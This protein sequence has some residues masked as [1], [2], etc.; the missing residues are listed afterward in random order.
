MN[1]NMGCIDT[2][3]FHIENYENCEMNSNMGC[4]D[5]SDGIHKFPIIYYDEQ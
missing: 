2:Y 4:I 1:S 3:S 5:T